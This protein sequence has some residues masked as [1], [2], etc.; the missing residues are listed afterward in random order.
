MPGM[1]CGCKKK[2]QCSKFVESLNPYKHAEITADYLD[3]S[4]GGCSCGPLDGTYIL[5]LD[6]GFVFAGQCRYTYTLPTPLTVCPNRPGFS[7][8]FTLTGFY[9]RFACSGSPYNQVLVAIG[10]FGGLGDDWVRIFSAPDGEVPK[11]GN[12]LGFHSASNWCNPLGGH[13]SGAL[14]SASYRVFE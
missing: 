11:E 10:A 14:E 8:P 13:G 12:L 1:P 4:G 6:A 5:A 3:S 9:L 7:G 2:F